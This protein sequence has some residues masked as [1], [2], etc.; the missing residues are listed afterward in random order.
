M[1][2]VQIRLL[3]SRKCEIHE[4]GDSVTHLVMEMGILLSYLK[5]AHLFFA[6][7]LKKMKKL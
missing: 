1:L 3:I 7:L 2:L 4:V 6:T 5:A